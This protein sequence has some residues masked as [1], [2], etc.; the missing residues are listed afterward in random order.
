MLRKRPAAEAATTVHSPLL[1][2]RGKEEKVISFFLA[3]NFLYFGA[4]HDR[5]YLG[6]FNQRQQRQRQS[7]PDRRYRF[8]VRWL[9]WVHTG[10]ILALHNPAG[11]DLYPM[12]LPNSPV[13][14]SGSGEGWWW[15][16]GGEA[17]IVHRGLR[18]IH[19]KSSPH[20]LLTD[21][22]NDGPPNNT[23]QISLWAQV[24]D[25]FGRP[26]A[27]PLSFSDTCT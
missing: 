15:G 2:A 19:L 16:M 20:S 18:H 13:W 25:D 27:A 22:L 6:H 21:T 11:L 5:G 7:C 12:L 24:L 14:S 10:H 8:I 23:E 17:G 3:L 9:H 4:L 26:T 1:A